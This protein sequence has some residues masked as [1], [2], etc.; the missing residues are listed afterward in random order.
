MLRVDGSLFFG[1]VPHVQSRLAGMRKANPE[2]KHLLLLAQSINFVDVAGAELLV[3]EAQSRRAAGGKQ[4]VRRR[5]P[6]VFQNGWTEENS[7]QDLANDRRLP[8]SLH[9]FAQNAGS[10]QENC[11]G[12]QHNSD[13]MNRHGGHLRGARPLRKSGDE[14]QWKL[15]ARWND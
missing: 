15:S 13:V 2:Q 8:K 7:R 10:A 5:R 14:R 6:E 9:Q 1:A 11:K 3:Q 12:Q 4:I